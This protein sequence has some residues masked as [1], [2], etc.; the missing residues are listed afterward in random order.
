MIR[1]RVFF[2]LGGL[3]IASA[4]ASLWSTDAKAA[5]FIPADTDEIISPLKLTAIDFLLP[6]Y[7]TWQQNEKTF[8]AVYFGGNILNLGL[9]YLAYLNY[10]ASESAYQSALTQQTASGADLQILKNLADRGQLFLSVAI[11]V[12]VVLRFFSAYHTYS[13]AAAKVV[14][15][16]PRYEFYPEANGGTRA[17]AGYYFNF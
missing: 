4:S 11:V 1:L 3:L 7:G 15:S 14:Q 2:L 5:R 8:A 6:G 9:I 10:S 17:Q 16:G 13:L 12:N